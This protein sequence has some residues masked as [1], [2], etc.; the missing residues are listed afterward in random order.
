[1][2]KLKAIN[3]ILSFFILTNLN[4]QINNEKKNIDS[5]FFKYTENDFVVF[6][7]NKEILKSIFLKQ[8]LT[9]IYISRDSLN[10]FYQL[11]FSL[12]NNN[13]ISKNEVIL[14]NGNYVRNG[15]SI[16]FNEKG[17][18]SKIYNY[19]LGEL[20]G[21]Y[22]L[23]NDLGNTILE[24]GNYKNGEKVGNWYLYNS[25]GKKMRKLSYNK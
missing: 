2:E 3:T 8:K 24:K 19:S 25:N 16:I 13:I 15:L 1:M 23:F 6:K 4:C 5:M 22:L 10:S 20:N 21:E 17:T 18:V 9:V 14:L 11:F 7:H 12:E